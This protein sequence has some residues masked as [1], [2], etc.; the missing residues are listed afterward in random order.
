MTTITINKWDEFNPR[1]DRQR[2]YWFRLNNDFFSSPDLCDLNMEQ[3]WLWVCLLA[4]A[5]RMGSATF[6][7]K[8][9]YFEKSFSL[10]KSKMDKA[11]EELSKCGVVVVTER[12]PDGY[13]SVTERCPTIQ[14]K[15]Y[16]TNNTNKQLSAVAKLAPPENSPDDLLNC[17]PQETRAR[18]VAL[19]PDELFL[20][21]ELI[22]AHGYYVTDNPTKCPKSV[23][24]WQ[25]ALSMWFERA[26]TWQAKNTKGKSN[27]VA[28]LTAEDLARMMTGGPDESA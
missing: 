20:K 27:N 18:W 26:W 8:P 2:H 16:N 4:H 25:R 1:K 6:E 24:G 21:R 28:D 9:S 12:L 17:I 10:T 13:Q 14:N 5:S 19:Y 15:Q 23:K 7:Y 22:K 11:L 3:K